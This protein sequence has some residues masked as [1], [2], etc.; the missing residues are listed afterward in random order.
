MK[1]TP[2]NQELFDVVQ[3][4]LISTRML[5]AKIASTITTEL[6]I[7]DSVVALGSARIAE[8]EEYEVEL[9][10]SPLFTPSNADRACCEAALSP[11]GINSEA[12]QSLQ[13]ELCRAD[14]SCPVV[15]GLDRG[16]L[17]IPPVVIER[18]VRLLGLTA[19]I[20]EHIVEL[21]EQVVGVE[22][23]NQAFSLA[24]RP[25]WKRSNS[26][27]L[28]ADCLGKMVQKSS[29]ST[30]KM[31]FLTSFVRTY[32]PAESGVLLASL[33]NMVAAYARDKDHPVYSR[34]LAKK[35]ENSLMPISCSKEVRANR[36]AMADALLVDFS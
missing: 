24:R 16:S 35:Q 6:E 18:Y 17:L 27:D 21:L 15:Y 9:L 4:L 25:V 7:D 1:S 32:R 23:R 28:L 31:D 30:E 3:G 29:F 34:N 5:T 13:D 33:N 19:S 2:A 36:I 11:S 12:L 22:Q 14:I 10:L 20:S 8:L 26:C